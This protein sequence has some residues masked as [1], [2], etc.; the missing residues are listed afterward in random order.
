MF[1]H[2]QWLFIVYY[3]LQVEE[4]RG[5]FP[6]AERPVPSYREYYPTERKNSRANHGVVSPDPGCEIEKED[7]DTTLQLGYSSFLISSL[8]FN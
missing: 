1:T 8:A 6:P 3:V 2:F 5:F 7:S 4:L